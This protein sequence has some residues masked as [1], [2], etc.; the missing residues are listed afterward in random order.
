M[1]AIVAVVIFIFSDKYYLKIKWLS[2]I[3]HQNKNSLNIIHNYFALVLIIG[4]H[5]SIPNISK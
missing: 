2:V 5:H 3:V 4:M 1:I